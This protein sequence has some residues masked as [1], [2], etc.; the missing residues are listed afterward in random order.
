MKI[1]K[2]IIIV[3]GEP[4][5]VFTEI[6]SKVLN[7]YSD[8]KKLNYPI[9][10]I[11]SKKLILAQ[12]KL[13]KKNLFFN[14]IDKKNL[15]H[16]NLGNKIYLIDIDYKF[17]KPFEKISFK[18]KR[19]IS[20][21]FDEGMDIINSK[22]SK[23]LING[24]VS[25]K[26]FL[27]NKYPGVTE[28]I[29][30]KS[31]NKITKNSVMLIY[32]KNFSVSP[33]TTHIA[34]KNVSKKINKEIIF[35]NILTINNFYLKNIKIKPKIA[36]LGLNPHCEDRSK[37]NEEKL[38]IIPAIKKLRK[39]KIDINGP[40]SADTF[41]IKNNLS[42]FDSVVGMYHDQ[43]LTPFKTI[44]KFDA[45]NITL[46]L[47]FIRISVDHG[48]NELMLGKNKSNTKSL[49]NIFNFINSIK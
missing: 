8:K 19:Y 27:N 32:N 25:K 39:K 23:I 33:I 41:F 4:N 30:D 9:I 46:G 6:L 7:N 14:L 18:S 26:H 10:L 35:N 31:K 42:K 29:F 38:V 11:G 3:L 17:R 16:K 2:P 36:V 13:L 49:E 20:K 22:I 24:P 34:L 1:K 44:Y 15:N 48:P 37:Y 40:F 12:L 43:V 28:Y 47:P 45:S 21:C 5:S